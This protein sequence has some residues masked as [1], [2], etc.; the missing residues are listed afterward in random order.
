MQTKQ[1]HAYRELGRR[2]KSGEMLPGQ[3]IVVS[4]LAQEI[5]TSAI[6]IREALLRLEADGLVESTPHVGAVVC[7][8]TGQMI[9]RTLE[10]LAVLEG[11]ATR[12]AADRAS[13]IEPHLLELNGAM[14]AAAEREQWGDFSTANR[15]FHFAIYGVV[16]NTVLTKAIED[17]W[18]QL[19]TYLSA[20]AFYLMPDRALGSVEEH[21]RIIEALARPDGDPDALEAL[22]RNH[23]FN[24][25]KRLRPNQQRDQSGV[26]FAIDGPSTAAEQGSSPSRR[27]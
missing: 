26:E 1:D 23:K 10:T 19:D 12:L 6:P 11:Y 24:T 5:G 7:H 15:A 14:R 2:I 20:A 13:E 25:A 3:R 17:L 22:A 21:A 18:S 16:S 27:G 9:E 4:R 8:I